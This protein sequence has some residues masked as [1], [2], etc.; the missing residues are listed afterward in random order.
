MMRS[1]IRMIAVAAIASGTLG[2]H[3]ATDGPVSSQSYDVHGAKIHVEI[4][5][6]GPPIVFLHGG[7]VFFDNNFAGQRDYF[8]SFRKVVGIDRRGHGHSPDDAR[9]F[10]YAEMTEDTAA[11]LEKLALGPVDIVG[12]SDGGNI[13]LLLAARHPELVRRLVV[14]G[15]N[16]RA[17]LPPEELAR[18]KAWTAEQHAERVKILA[19]RVPPT[20]RTDYE[21]VSPDG[22]GHWM[23]IVEKSYRMWLTPTVIEGSELKSIGI[24]VLV[25]A[26]DHDFTSLEET[27]EIYRGLAKGELFIMPGTGHGTLSE[28]PDLANLAIREFLEKPAK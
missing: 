28:R 23:T 3:A 18:R 12:H 5:G 9:P 27:I 22:P 2:A 7:L 10:S 8:S 24:P 1:S 16:L 11:L 17:G 21:K 15:A 6:S 19:E 4:A 26:G 14:S 20:F 13:G 25:I